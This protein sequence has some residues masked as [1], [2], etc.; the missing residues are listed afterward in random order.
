MSIGKKLAWSAH[1]EFGRNI[2]LAATVIMVYKRV[3]AGGITIALASI[4]GWGLSR[5][6]LLTT[7]VL[8]IGIITGMF[9]LVIHHK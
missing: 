7:A 4:V 1:T 9:I 8:T 2:L 6:P 3:L 5:D